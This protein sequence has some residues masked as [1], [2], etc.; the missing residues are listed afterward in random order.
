MNKKLVNLFWGVGLI[1]AGG[2]AL[3]ESM[4]YIQD[5]A[6]AIWITIFAVISLISLFTYFQSGVKHWGWL[7]PAGIGAA[8]ALVIVLSESGVESAIVAAPIFIAIGLP[9]MVAYFLDRTRH[10]WALIPA[11]V[12][13]F[14]TLL[15]V[16]VDVLPDEWVGVGFL[17]FLAAAF[18]VIYLGNRTR[19]WAAFVAYILLVVGFTPL[20][21]L[22]SRPE[23]AGVM[24]LFAMGLPFLGA[25]LT[26][27][28]RWWAIIPAGILLTLG[29][30]TAIM[31]LPGLPDA[32]LASNLPQAF[33]LAGFAATFAVVW[34][35]HAKNW[36][37]Y[38]TLVI[39]ALSVASLFFN[40]NSLWV[41]PVIAIALGVYL[42]FQSLRKEAVA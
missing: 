29:L 5:L 13:A 31:L 20:M 36:A 25:Y 26:S 16:G 3:A 24:I 28:E 17:F 6:P 2:L 35:R 11:G 21:A 37:K 19:T 27:A 15:M 14:L 42:L 32:N 41:G 12:M 34:L 18:L 40:D 10:W 38:L 1:A 30:V 22:G 7:F 9:F 8:L 23:L 4:G 39:A 33:S